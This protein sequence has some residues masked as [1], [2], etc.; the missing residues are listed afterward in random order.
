MGH[1]VVFIG[2]QNFRLFNFSNRNCM[3]KHCLVLAKT[4]SI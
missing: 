2:F 1:Y 4:C 3:T